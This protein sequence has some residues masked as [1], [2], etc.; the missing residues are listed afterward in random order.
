MALTR[1][2]GF[3]SVVAIAHGECQK[4][5]CSDEENAL[6]SVKAAKHSSNATSTVCTNSFGVEFP[7]GQ[8]ECCG[9]ICMAAGGTCCKNKFNEDFAC[10]AGDS[11]CGNACASAESECC[12]GI[13]GNQ[14]PVAKGSDCSDDYVKCTNRNGNKFLCGPDSSC[15]GD[16]C[17]GLGGVCCV[18]NLGNNFVCGKDSTCCG[19]SCAAPK[20]KCCSNNGRQFPVTEDTLC[21]GEAVSSTKCI[22]VTATLS[23]AAPN[24]VAAAIFVWEPGEC[25]APMATATSSHAAKAASVAETYA[26]LRETESSDSSVLHPKRCLVG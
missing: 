1:I 6:L 18:N 19:N 7:C 14:Y 8:G 17:S 16:V 9:N 24:Q 26:A 15:C 2:L 23:S 10:A 11:C 4:G 12:A 13:D 21:P 22:T 20:S 25:A 5:E 3:L